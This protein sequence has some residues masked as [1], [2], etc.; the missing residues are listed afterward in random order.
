M[1]WSRIS[2][3]RELAWQSLS[4]VEKQVLPEL[5]KRGLYDFD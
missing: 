1:A 4:L 3:A 2:S 5:R